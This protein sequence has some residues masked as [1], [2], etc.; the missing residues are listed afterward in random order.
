MD[1]PIPT[2]AVTESNR[3]A[4]RTIAAADD[5]DNPVIQGLVEEVQRLRAELLVVRSQ[6]DYLKGKVDEVAL[7]FISS[8]GWVR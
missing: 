4:I 2:D 7:E 5:L 3:R 6:R 8:I 1:K